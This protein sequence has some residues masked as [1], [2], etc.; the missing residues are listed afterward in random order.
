[1]IV[2]YRVLILG[3]DE[4]ATILADFLRKK[5][6]YV[7]IVFS[8]LKDVSE[9]AD[10]EFQI[11]ILDCAFA[12]DGFSSVDEIITSIKE[13]LRI[14][15]V[16]CMSYINDE[17]L[18]LPLYEDGH[19]YKP[20]TKKD[21]EVIYKTLL[22]NERKELVFLFFGLRFYAS[23]ERASLLKSRVEDLLLKA[24]EHEGLVGIDTHIPPV[25]L[26]PTVTKL[27]ISKHK[28]KRSEK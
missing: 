25:D 10:K 22:N 7:E 5:D 16:Y 28:K 24:F 17:F 12:I 11:C 9:I 21:L 1:V 8:D 4:E 18:E 14:P 26:T 3:T 6:F 2:L 20:L 23:P 15:R 27:S 19:F 13:K